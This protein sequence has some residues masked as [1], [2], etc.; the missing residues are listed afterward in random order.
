MGIGRLGRAASNHAVFVD[1]DGVIN[2]NVLNPRTG[3]YESPHRPEDFHLADG[4]VP[5]LARLQAAGFRLFLVSNQP[6]YAKGKTTLAMLEDIHGR[7]VDALNAAGIVFSAFY[8]C[9]H[10]PDSKVLGYGGPCS[11]RKPSAFFLFKAADEFGLDL[12]QSWMVGD[13]VTDVAC[14]R[15]AG[16]HTIRVAE[17]H[18]ATRRADETPAEFEAQDLAAAADVILARMAVCAADAGSAG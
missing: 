12:A 13:R 14:G 6:S 15:A 2:R 11:C 16:V 3:T 4:A 7:L 18:L 9:F 17:D 10:H 8:Y 5:A 1:R